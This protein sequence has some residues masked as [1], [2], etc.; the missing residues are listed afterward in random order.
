MKEYNGN[1]ITGYTTGV[2]QAARTI[3]GLNYGTREPVR[4]CQ[5]MGAMGTPQRLETEVPCR[6]GLI[7][8]SDDT[9]VMEEERR[10]Q[11]IQSNNIKQLARG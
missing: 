1:L 9:T 10:N 7:R 5:G 11:V 2:I 6:D 3:F 8:S 4:Q